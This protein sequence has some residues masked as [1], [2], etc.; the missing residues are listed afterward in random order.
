[1]DHPQNSWIT[2][3]EAAREYRVSTAV[4]YRA[5]SAGNLPVLKIGGSWRIDRGSIERAIGWDPE[6][7][8]RLALESTPRA[9]RR[10][11]QERAFRLLSGRDNA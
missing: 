1:M 9:R 11:L 5:C 3:K 2:V 6:S 8:R 7:A 10:Q 4:I